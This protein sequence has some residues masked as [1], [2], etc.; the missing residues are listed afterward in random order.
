MN[1]L[2]V[3]FLFISDEN[4]ADTFWYFKYL[5]DLVHRNF[6]RSQQKIQEDLDSLRQIIADGLHFLLLSHLS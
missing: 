4:E 6:E 5:M 2:V 1:D 3:P